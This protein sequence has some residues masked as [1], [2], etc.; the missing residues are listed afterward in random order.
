[1]TGGR[2]ALCLRLAQGGELGKIRSRP[3]GAEFGSAGLRKRH[4]PGCRG[5]G[6]I[7]RGWRDGRV[8][9]DAR[10]G[11]GRCLAMDQGRKRILLDGAEHHLS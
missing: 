5:D 11:A 1:M 8:R 4:E 9:R 6:G 7:S 10:N 3:G 2:Q